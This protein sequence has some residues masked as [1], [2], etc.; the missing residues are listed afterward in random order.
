MLKS[1]GH[2]LGPRGSAN[3]A[4]SKPPVPAG[5][6]QVLKAVRDRGRL[7]TITS[8]PPATERDITVRAVL[9]AADG[10]RLSGLVRLLAEGVL[11]LSVG[12]RFP[13]EQ[14]GPALA[15]ARHGAHGSAIVLQP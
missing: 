2:A 8:D 6:S 9:V 10:R 11:T 7:A 4:D 3:L 15:R 13:L 1:L 12:A 14:A 5:A